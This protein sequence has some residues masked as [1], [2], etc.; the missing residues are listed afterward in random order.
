MKRLLYFSY[1][2]NGLGRLGAWAHYVLD[3]G[4]RWK[5]SGPLWVVVSGP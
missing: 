4:T 3:D 5:Q 2:R 1:E